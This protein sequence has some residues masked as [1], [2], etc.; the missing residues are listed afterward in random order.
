MKPLAFIGSC[1]GIQLYVEAAERQG[2][3]VAGIIDSDYYGN[4]AEF[5]GLP[6][7]GTEQELASYQ[8][9]YDF[10]IATNSSP[11]A[12]QQ[13]DVQKRLHLID[14]VE[15]AGIQCVNLIDP[16]TRIARDVKLGHGVFIGYKCYIEH[17]VE[18][19]DFCQV[20]YD[21]GISHDVRIGRNTV[22]QRK[23]GIGN[24]T[25]GDNV[26]VGMWVNIFCSEHVQVGSGATI[27]QG[28]WVARDVAENEHVRLTREAIRIYKNL[29]KI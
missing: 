15:A 20:F 17:G 2:L 5:R 16:E 28:L 6:V 8:D 19:G 25:I 24:T 9:Q 14:L 12:D 26:Y 21:A 18:I 23:C 3:Q 11:D 22:I 29:S 4:T 1:S 27:N 7:I 13:R 10:F